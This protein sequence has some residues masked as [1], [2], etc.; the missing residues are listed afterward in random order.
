MGLV[1]FNC[2]GE[3]LVENSSTSSNEA[4][5]CCCLVLCTEPVGEAANEKLNL[6]HFSLGSGR[7]GSAGA[8]LCYVVRDACGSMR[9]GGW[10]W[11]WSSLGHVWHLHL[12]HILV[13]TGPYT[14]RAELVVLPSLVPGGMVCL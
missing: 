12:P 11:G 4:P 3:E 10:F 6:L 7:W 1:V 2:F 14:T 5:G 9:L 8:W 13:E